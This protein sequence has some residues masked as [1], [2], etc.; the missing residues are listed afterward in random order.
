MEDAVG[1][2]FPYLRVAPFRMTLAESQCEQLAHGAVHALGLTKSLLRS[3]RAI[4]R[5]LMRVRSTGMIGFGESDHDRDGK[6]GRRTIKHGKICLPRMR[7][8]QASSNA[9]HG[10][11]DIVSFSK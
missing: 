2:G 5:H 1:D 11:I 7:F 6:G 4:D 8:P 3:H 10:L 9:T